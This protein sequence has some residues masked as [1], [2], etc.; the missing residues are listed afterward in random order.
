MCHY[1]CSLCTRSHLTSIEG[2]TSFDVLSPYSMDS[3]KENKNSSSDRDRIFAKHGHKL[4][5]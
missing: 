1:G 5:L 2:N 3:K 4:L